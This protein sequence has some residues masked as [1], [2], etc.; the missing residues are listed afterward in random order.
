MDLPS[1]PAKPSLAEFG[2]T[3]HS[4]FEIDASGDSVQSL[5]SPNKS[6]RFEGI[7]F[8]SSG[9]II[10]V[11]TADTNTVFLFRRKADGLFE[12]TPYWSIDGPSAG[13]NYP[14]DVSFSRSGDTELLAVAQRGGAIAI[15]EKNRA[16][17]N[18][19]PDPSF[20][21]CGPKTKLNFSDGVAFVPPNNDYLA[22]CNLEIG[23]ICFYRRVSR[24][25]IAFELEPVFELKHRSLSHPDG[26][27]FSHCGRWL[28]IANHR[29]HSISMFQRRN[30]VL[31]RGKLKYGPEPVTIIKDPGLRHPHSVAFTPETNHLVATNAGANYISVYEPQRHNFRMRWSQAPVVQQTVGPDHIFK[32]VNARNKMEGG[33]KGI[34]INRSS[35]AICSPEHGIKIFSFREHLSIR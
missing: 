11:A 30:R 20:E 33:P 1:L 13:L 3:G 26:L 9:N 7:A 27:A 15:Y 24:S 35:L 5:A 22:A 31:S 4:R 34:A 17:D 16:N 18:F 12:D 25:P 28:A 2:L 23:S 32:E 10:G 14:H 6:Q 8:S 29:N 21:I 19:G